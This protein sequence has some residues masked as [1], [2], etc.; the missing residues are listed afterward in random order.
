LE[1][2]ATSVNAMTRRTMLHEI[3]HIWLD[4]NTTQSL[5]DRFLELRGLRSW[6]ASSDPWE[7]RG[8]EQGA[9]IMSWALGERILTAQIPTQRSRAARAG[10]RAPD[11]RRAS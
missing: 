6:N 2:Q 11:W 5:R 7:L 10:I 1:P 9:E 8:S 4:T 3:G